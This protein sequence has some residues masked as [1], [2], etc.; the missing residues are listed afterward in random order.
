MSVAAQPAVDYM[1]LPG[2]VC[3][4]CGSPDLRAI[5]PG[6]AGAAHVALGWLERPVALRGWCSLACACAAANAA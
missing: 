2:V 1:R 5:A 3:G 6:Q 4:V